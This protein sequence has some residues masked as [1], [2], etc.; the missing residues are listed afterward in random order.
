MWKK[1]IERNV[2]EKKMAKTKRTPMKRQCKG[3]GVVPGTSRDT[4]EGEGGAKKLEKSE[5]L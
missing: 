2:F 1:E 3:D 5:D 4:G